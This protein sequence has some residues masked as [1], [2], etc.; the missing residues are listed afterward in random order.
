MY[1]VIG[2]D[3]NIYGPVDLPTLI[4][5]RNEARVTPDTILVDETGNRFPASTIQALFPP[6]PAPPANPY[7]ASPTVYPRSEYGAGSGYS[8]QGDAEAK[9]QLTY[10]YVCAG[11]SFFCCPIVFGL[12]GWNCAVKAEKLGHPGGSVAKYVVL[13]C[14]IISIVVGALLFRMPG[15]P[16]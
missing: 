9:K 5:W 16:K 8:Q 4:A 12:V 13:V 10:A 3:G 11:L 7:G 15:T 6:I 14:A 1:S 2:S